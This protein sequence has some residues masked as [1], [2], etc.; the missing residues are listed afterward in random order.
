MPEQITTKAASNPL[1]GTL[2]PPFFKAIGEYWDQNMTIEVKNNL[3]LWMNFFVIAF[4]I[5]ILWLLLNR[6]LEL[7]KPRYYLKVTFD[8]DLDDNESNDSK[9][10]GLVSGLHTL[11][12][13]TVITFEIHKSKDFVGF[14][15][16]SSDQSVLNHIRSELS[17]INNLSVEILAAECEP[18]TSQF[19]QYMARVT[20]RPYQLQI[21]ASLEYGNFRKD[22]LNLTQN[23][24]GT[25]QSIPKDQFGSVVFA[26]RP[27]IKEYKVKPP[28]LKRRGISFKLINIF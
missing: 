24:I 26:F 9:I 10:L 11:S 5:Y 18:L 16:S 17:R 28:H 13:S 22:Q 2:F 4:V 23:L 27:M 21:V 25:M 20:A 15:F 8:H 14:L 12:K 19:L 1:D 6:F 7:R 3:V